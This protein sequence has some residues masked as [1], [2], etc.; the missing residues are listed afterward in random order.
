MRMENPSKHS[1]HS[2]RSQW[3]RGDREGR[4]DSSQGQK[5]RGERIRGRQAWGQKPQSYRNTERAEDPFRRRIAEEA[6]LVQNAS[7]LDKNQKGLKRAMQSSKNILTVREN[8][9]VKI[10]L[11]GRTRLLKL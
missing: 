8:C 9:C 2:D 5:V 6:S 3:G 7:I 10:V 4:Q 11:R 1:N